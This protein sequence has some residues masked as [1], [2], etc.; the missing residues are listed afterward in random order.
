M[1]KTKIVVLG[2]LLITVFFWGPLVLVILG[3]LL[4]G[5]IIAVAAVGSLFGEFVILPFILFVAVI[6]FFGGRA[7]F[8]F[9]SRRVETD[10]TLTQT[11]ENTVLQNAQYINAA[12][13]EGMPDEVIKNGL[14]QVGWGPE[15]VAS[16]FTVAER[17][18]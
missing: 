7:C 11:P 16:A 10:E 2:F 9:F 6:V 18:Q 17:I 15:D 5:G 4:C 13:K 3:E 1:S 8:R 12:R 14:L